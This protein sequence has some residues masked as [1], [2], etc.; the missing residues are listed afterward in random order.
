MLPA[1]L[2]GDLMCPHMMLSDVCVVV[3]EK[4]PPCETMSRGHS[5]EPEWTL[6]R[7]REGGSH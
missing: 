6:I 1:A 3:E 4:Q 7:D 5:V 2:L